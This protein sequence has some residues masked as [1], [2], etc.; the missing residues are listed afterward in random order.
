MATR[1]ARIVWAASV[2]IALGASVAQARGEYARPGPHVSMQGVLAV[3]LWE[4]ELN[5]RI[6]TAGSSLAASTLSLSGG[7]DLR[8]GYR[9]HERVAAEMG[10]DW[11][12]AY[13]IRLAGAE[14]ARASNW[15]YYV[16]AKIYLLTE[17]IQPHLSLGMGAYHLDYAVPS[18]PVLVDATAFAPRF[19]AGVD[20]YVDWRWGL[21]AELDYVL[22][23]RQLVDRDRVSISVGAFYRF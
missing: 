5:T 11:V 13:A 17:T 22:G 3:P 9:F 6:A 18:G 10:F 7:L 21:T 12:S 2:L 19:G 8:A 20:Y 14:I 16:D 23:S 4:S 15:M 1:M